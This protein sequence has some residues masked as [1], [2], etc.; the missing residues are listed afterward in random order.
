MLTKTRAAFTY[1]DEDVVKE[2]IV[3]MIHPKCEYT[4]IT[5]SSHKQKDMYK[6]TGANKEQQQN[7]HLV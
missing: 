7:W 5:Y 1:F 2:L 6:E 3:S 4:L